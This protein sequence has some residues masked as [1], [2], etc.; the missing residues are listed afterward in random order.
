MDEN[1]LKTL[2]EEGIAAAK[3]GQ[4]EQA[5]QCL[6]R[7][8]EADET[9][10]QAW[11]WLSGVV[12]SLEDRQVCLENVLALNPDSGPAK[13][14]LAWI[15]QQRAKQGLPSLPEAPQ[16]VAP[17]PSEPPPPPTSPPS[18]PLSAATVP[19]AQPRSAPSHVAASASIPPVR[20]ERRRKRESRSSILQLLS[21]GWGLYGLLSLVTGGFVLFFSL[22]GPTLLEDPE[23][24]SSLRPD[25][26]ATLM[27][28]VEMGPL[29]GI[30]FIVLAGLCFALTVGLLMRHKVA[31]YT[32][33]VV[34]A[35]SFGLFFYS[36]VF[37][38]RGCCCWPI[39]PLILFGLT[40]FIRDDFAFEEVAVKERYVP[41]SPAYHYNRGAEY[42]KQKRL[43][44]AI[45]EWEEAVSLAPD[46][47]HY[48]NALALAYAGRG[49]KEKAIA[50]L[51]ETLAMAP[52]DAETRDNLEAVRRG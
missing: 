5:R 38:P 25:Q 45:Q 47:V 48:R 23:S 16:P 18:P 52:D 6:M 11:L 22:M 7:V 51:E 19:P 37:K 30:S 8:V 14:G 43:D 4:K 1:L 9:N 41:S 15:T 12:E 35:L 33:F 50:L 44:L 31:F 36:A 40:F 10:E 32:S 24:W 13:K 28:I 49:Q 20:Y 17:P 39:T 42:V 21:A 29:W 27:V 34:A 3:A 2:L 26:I 46:D